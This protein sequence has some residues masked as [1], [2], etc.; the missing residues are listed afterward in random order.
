[1]KKNNLK[2]LHINKFYYP[3]IGGVET[4]VRQYS[5]HLSLY[6]TVTVLCV[7]KKFTLKTRKETINNV[8]IIR[9][10]SLG[11]YFSM[12]VSIAFFLIFFKIK[13]EY[14]II[15]FHEPFPLGSILS[16]FIKS[17]KKII[18]TWHSDIIKQKLLKKTVEIFQNLLC[19]KANIITAT[20]P[21]LLNFSDVIAKYKSKAIILPLSIKAEKE[22]SNSDKGYILC[23]GRL[24]YY[25]GIDILLQAYEKTKTEL[26][27]IIVGDGEKEIVD[28]IKKFSKTSSKEITF[29]NKFVTESEKTDYLKNCSFFVFPSTAPS[30]A[31]GI[32]QLEAMIHGKPVINT[33]LPT[34]VPYVSVDNITGITVNPGN[35][36]QLS[37]AIDELS[38]D[39]HLRNSL[40][41]AAH[42]RVLSEFS[43]EIVLKK[44]K[45]KYLTI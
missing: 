18:I 6:D 33:N 21:N 37:S 3:D 20:S 34:G 38:S 43:D 4:V 24:S 5:E 45:N 8:K 13:N 15:H 40:G 32:L 7:S 25:K 1:M 22:I 14:D 12:P 30:E 23:L 10:S 26:R 2:I 39:I 29:V 42:N 31:F 16:L 36:E 9:S 11:T 44:L 41:V 28:Q 27:L 17:N 19:K 35:I